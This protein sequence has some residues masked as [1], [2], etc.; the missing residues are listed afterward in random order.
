MSTNVH[1]LEFDTAHPDFINI[2]K[3]LP[4]EPTNASGEG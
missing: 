4:P 3:F 2:G 1:A